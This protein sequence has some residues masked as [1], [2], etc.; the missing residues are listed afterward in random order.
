MPPKSLVHQHSSECMIDEL[1]IFRIPPTLS[2]VEKCDTTAHFP[3]SA[4]E[5][6][7]LDFF[8][9]G[10]SEAYINLRKTRLYLKLSV[11]KND[12]TNLVAADSL[13][14]T[15]NFLNN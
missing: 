4:I 13:S 10:S 9:S 11:Q 12:G 15:G 5:S 1:N 14:S 6:H 3:I 2:Q 8:I 7:V